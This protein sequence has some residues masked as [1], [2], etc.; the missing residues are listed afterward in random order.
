MA[1]QTAF[2]SRALLENYW[3]LM[4]QASLIGC[5]NENGLAL[6]FLTWSVIKGE[7][8]KLKMTGNI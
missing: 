5:D 8:T 4:I 7:K 1:C 3:D 6:H 2:I